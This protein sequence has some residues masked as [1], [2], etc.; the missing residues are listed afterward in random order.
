MSDE[1]EA[2]DMGD[3]E[4]ESPTGEAPPSSSDDDGD[5]EAAADVGPNETVR[6]RNVHVI[7]DK[8][9][10]LFKAAA[11]DLRKQLHD[12]DA[13]LYELDTDEPP[14]K[15]AP[16]LPA[17]AV[18]APQVPVPASPATAPPA[19]PAPSLDPQVQQRLAE[20]NARAAE[21]DAREKAILDR[22]T[23]GDMAKLHEVYLDKGYAPAMVELVK[24]WTGAATD[25]ELA[26]EIADL[27][28]ELSGH[29]LGAQV[30][31]DIKA[32]LDSKRALKSVKA[33][34][35]RLDKR[36]SEL[37]TQREQAEQQAIID[38]VV[39]QLH[40][41]VT[42]PEHVTAYRFLAAEDNA[43][44][45]IYDVYDAQ[46]RR[47]GSKLTWQDAAK[48]AND[49]LETKWRE[50]YGKRAHLFSASPA[51]AGGAVAGEGKRHQGDPT[52]IRRSHTLTNAQ[53]ASASTTAPP[54]PEKTGRG[55]KWS[56]EDHR[57]ATKR[58]MREVFKANA[59]E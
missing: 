59:D 26:N 10:A 36:E 50:A 31:Q 1:Y 3:I 28:T 11:A 46:F 35:Q 53:A 15:P 38:R 52:G 22:E 58:K 13:D 16:A 30:P 39:T 5:W 56:M 33:H 20:V 9:K 54:P 21:L 25:A 2:A 34:Q 37:A 55:G 6:G 32:R 23:R 57:A 14:A 18:G 44:Q 29:S 49:Y 40:T 19:P 47:D 12:G 45:L 17:A 48:R 4:P 42:K 51:P 41:E 27:V 8:T 7:S 43:G 24:Q